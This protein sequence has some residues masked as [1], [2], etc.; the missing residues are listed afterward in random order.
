M[1]NRS[2]LNTRN[3][4]TYRRTEFNFFYH[5]FILNR[6]IE[7]YETSYEL[8]TNMYSVLINFKVRGKSPTL[9]SV[10]SQI[11]LNICCGQTYMRINPLFRFGSQICRWN[12]FDFSTTNCKW[13]AKIDCYIA[14]G[15]L[16]FWTLD[17][18]NFSYTM[19]KTK[20]GHMKDAHIS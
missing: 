2:H 4:E 19:R 20:T 12:E 6:S 3:G 16:L 9:M 5:A 13:G 14:A 11:C 7:S 1:H 18:P 10:S 8:V 17:Q 15:W